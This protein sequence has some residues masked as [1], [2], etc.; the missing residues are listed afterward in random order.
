MKRIG[1]LFLFF[2]LTSV[3][4]SQ[5]K[6]ELRIL[7]DASEDSNFE[8]ELWKE[9]P[10]E[11][12]AVTKSVPEVIFIK[13]N[14]IN[15]NP[16]DEFVFFRVRRIGKFGAKGFWTQVYSTTA[17]TNS[18]L[19]VPNEYKVEKPVVVVKK[20]VPKIDP[21]VVN[22]DSFVLVP[23]N[24]GTVSRFLTREKLNVSAQ[25]NTKIAGTKY[26]INGGNWQTTPDGQALAFQEEGE[27]DLEYYST[28]LLGNK[29]PIRSIQF[30]K[31]TKAPR[32]NVQWNDPNQ[33]NLDVPKFI[34]SATKISLQAVDS[35][36][37][38]GDS[39]Y[40]FFCQGIS[41]PS[42]KKYDSPISVGDGFSECKNNYRLLI[43]SV[44]K[45]GNREE[46]QDFEIKFGSTEK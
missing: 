20:E 24:S 39:F 11:D 43:Y 41:N 44:D 40:S 28:D 35:G 27:Y 37:G 19:S 34:S 26:R 15:V 21:P 8:L 10:G 42:F 17:D 3:I 18:P 16:K 31:D 33:G 14:R 4:W 22:T 2:C 1:I 25:T 30:I 13:G 12:D 7:I 29:E 38:S 45:V 9:A 5:P 32:T 36:S 6:K 46:V 23:N